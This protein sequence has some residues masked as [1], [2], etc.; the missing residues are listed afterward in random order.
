M[1]P[2]IKAQPDAYDRSLAFNFDDLATEAELYLKRVRAQAEQIVA[3]AAQ[4]AVAV[5][6]TAEAE[7]RVAGTKAI[8]TMIDQ[9]LAKQLE[10]VLPAMRMAIGEIEQSRHA[11]LGHWEKEAVR[12][13]TAM[14]A[15]VCRKEA[16]HDPQITLQLLKEALELAGSNANVRILLNPDDHA[17]LDQQVKSLV[18]AFSRLASATVVADPQISRG[19][20][21][22]ET[23]FGVI[24]QQFEAQLSR[25]EEEL[26]DGPA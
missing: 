2:V 18:E 15:R 14:A 5:R 8:E 25:I 11:W 26:I 19:G 9:K 3:K 16:I 24:D 1:P 22:V 20:C 23:E 10:T 7:G 17:G 4:E 12:L 21:R 13:A 6:K